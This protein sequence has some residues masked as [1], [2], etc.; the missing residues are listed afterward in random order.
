M[1]RPESGGESLL[2]SNE[3]L[4]LSLFLYEF[5]QVNYAIMK[6]SD[7]NMAPEAPEEIEEPGKNQTNYNLVD[8]EVAKY[9]NTTRIEIDEATSSRLKTMIDRRVLVVMMVTYFTQSLDKMTISFASIMGM[10]EDANLSG[11]QVRL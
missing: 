9:A 4:V 6:D 5:L 2:Y 10:L 3:P 1:P 11:S 7:V 8:Q